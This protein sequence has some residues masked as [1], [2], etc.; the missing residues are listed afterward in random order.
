[1]GVLAPFLSYVVL[2]VVELLNWFSCVVLVVFGSLALVVR[3]LQ[4][5]AVPACGLV[6]VGTIWAAYQVHAKG[7]VSSGDRE[8]PCGVFLAAPMAACS[9][10]ENYTKEWTRAMRVYRTLQDRCALAKV[11]YA[12]R[13]IKN[14]GKWEPN[15]VSADV[16]FEQLR[17]CKYFILVYLPANASTRTLQKQPKAPSSVF[18]EA[19][20]ALALGIPSMYFVRCEE[21]LPFMLRKIQGS[22]QVRICDLGNTEAIVDFLE[23]QGENL[24]GWV[25]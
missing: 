10:E 2:L 3:D 22:A 11:F 9:S 17:N 16:N 18:V 1:M 15:H 13:D 4:L 19:G 7:S 14:Y 21:D 25:K 6:C 8:K 12:G 5:C 23:K 20:Y 24:F